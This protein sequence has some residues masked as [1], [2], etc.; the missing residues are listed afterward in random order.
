MAARTL[1]ALVLCVLREPS[2]VQQLLGET[3]ARA[4]HRAMDALCS[5]PVIAPP[6][7]QQSTESGKGSGDL[8]ACVWADPVWLKEVAQLGQ[9]ASK[10]LGPAERAS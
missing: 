10:A 4:A 9:V 8:V 1:L 3:Q 2:A 6:Q 7:Q 5:K